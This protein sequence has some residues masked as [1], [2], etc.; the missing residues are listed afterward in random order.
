MIRIEQYKSGDT[1][2]VLRP[3]IF[4][5]SEHFFRLLEKSSGITPVMLVAYD[6]D[7]EKGH[8]L[9]MFKCD[10]RIIP[11]GVYRWCSIY[12]EGVYSDDCQDRNEVFELFVERLL[13][14][15]DFRY[16]FIE[17]RYIADSRISYRTFS[18]YNFVPRNDLRIYISLHSRRPEERLSRAYHAYIR[19]AKVRGVTYHRATGKAEIEAGVKMLKKYYASKVGR[20]F[21][22]SGLLANMLLSAD[23]EKL[24]ARMFTVYNKD[25]K[26]IGCSICVYSDDRVFL[27][28]NC[29]LRKSYPLLY[30]GIMS[31][32][33]AIKDAYDNG[34]PHFEFAVSGMPLKRARGYRKF[35]LNFG[36]KQVSTLRW[37]RYRWEWFNKILRKIYV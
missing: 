34:V 2:P 13:K 8:L 19:K 25:G 26:M 1:V 22:P 10:F 12:S 18:K 3:G 30:P 35:L 20:Y 24:D 37:Y 5:H 23:K 11:P 7:E 33:A 6:G 17:A 14:M 36:G 28:Y 27:L 16:L 29:G 4:F 21:A 32:W 9:A 31:V 15:M